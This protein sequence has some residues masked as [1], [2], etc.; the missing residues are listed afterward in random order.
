VD[1]KDRDLAVL[2][3]ESHG[4]VAQIDL[5]D[6]NQIREIHEIHAKSL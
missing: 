2:I 5:I 1:Q 3:Y 6:Q 4:R